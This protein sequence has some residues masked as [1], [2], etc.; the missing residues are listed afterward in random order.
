MYIFKGVAYEK[1]K[2]QVRSL[3]RSN[4]KITDPNQFYSG[5]CINGATTID[6]GGTLEGLKPGSSTAPHGVLDTLAHLSGPQFPHL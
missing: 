1:Y 4:F 3:V 6:K 5:F 2:G